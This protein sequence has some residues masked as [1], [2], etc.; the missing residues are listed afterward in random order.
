MQ[1]KTKKILTIFRWQ[2]NLLTIA[3]TLTVPGKI[4]YL[5]WRIFF[6]KILTFS[7]PRSFTLNEVFLPNI[8]LLWVNIVQVDRNVFF[9]YGLPKVNLGKKMSTYRKE[10]FFRRKFFLSVF[11]PHFVC[12]TCNM[13]GSSKL[14]RNFSPLL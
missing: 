5:Y 8:F 10:I 14:T 1:W 9:L 11:L 13:T 7:T 2:I 12:M 4:F 3:L 6:F